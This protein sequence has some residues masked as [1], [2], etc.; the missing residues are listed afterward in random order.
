MAYALHPMLVPVPGACFAGALLTDIAYWRST[1]MMWADFSAWLITA[2][3]ILSC[4]A[5]LV[6]L[7]GLLSNRL[8]RARVWAL[9]YVIGNGT[10]LILAA[11]NMLVHTR[12]AWTSVVPWGLILSAAVVVI[13]VFTAWMGWSLASR[14]VVGAAE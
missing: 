1:E 14:P 9:P 12:D 4:L 3:V 11:I 13:L 7:I 6:G 10:M 8:V 2:G 5:T